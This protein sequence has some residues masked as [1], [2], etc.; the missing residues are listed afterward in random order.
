[1]VQEVDVVTE[2]AEEVALPD[3][4]ITVMLVRM[5]QLI[6]VYAPQ[7]MMYMVVII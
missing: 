6:Q 2:Q 1:M 7:L 4:L 3:L 5:D